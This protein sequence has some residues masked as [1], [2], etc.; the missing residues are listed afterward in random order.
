MIKENEVIINGHRTNFDFYK[1]LGY[2]IEY[3]KPCLIKIKDLMFGSNVKITSICDSCF[4][5]NTKTA[6][7]DYYTYTKG[8]TQDFYCNKC[9]KVRSKQTCLDKYGVENPMQNK[10]VKDKLKKSLLNKHGVE[11]YSKTDEFKLKYKTTCLNKYGVE[12]VFQ[13]LEIQDKIKNSNLEKYGVEYVQQAEII[14]QKSDNT[15]LQ[16]YGF[17]KYSQ[18][19]EC[20]LK[21]INSNL[22]KYGS[23]YS[24]TDEFKERYK[25]TNLEK[26]GVEFYTQTEE[27]KIQSKNTNLEKYGVNHYSKTDEFKSLVKVK[28]EVLTKLSY[29]NLIGSDYNII[30]YTNKNFIIKHL[31]CN[32]E[33]LINR[34]ALYGRINI[35]ICL[36]TECLPI[37]S[38]HSNMEL[39]LQDY[40][41]SIN[42]GYEVGNKK[43]LGGKE[44]DIYIPE[45]NLAIEMNGIYWHSEIYLDEDYH[46]NK[47]LLCK[48]KGIQLLHIWEDDWKYK[49]NIIKSIILNKLGLIKNKIFARKCFI[50]EVNSKE[51][52]LFLDINHIQGFSPSQI[53]LGLYFNNELVSLMT[54]GWRYTNAKRE[55]ELIRFCNKLNTNI[56]GGSSKLFKYFLNNNNIDEIISYADISLFSGGL[57]GLL[58]FKKSH[59][60]KPNYFWIIDGI[61]KHRFN[62]NKMKLVKEGFD[63]KKTE[64]EIMHE[65]GYYRIFSCG[66]EKYIFRK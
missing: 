7:K 58:G 24:N 30:E 1:K 52:R 37:N 54:L 33:F 38:Q 60:S 3:K 15:N 2:D 14:R 8:F 41:N 23:N 57:Y 27:Y 47:T 11:H 40:L 62:Y 10:E 42:I 66:Q 6:F 34:D 5:E 25:N 4:I 9:N 43:I 50:K 64:V 49:R 31:I 28:R 48:D 39:E 22:E 19:E 46:I 29:E 20:K 21:V 59:L 55:Y 12:N 44:L 35:D 56:I 45:H 18:T 26:Y 16:K 53:K 63:S 51:A 65:R 13:N 17:K 32:K 61:K 36:C